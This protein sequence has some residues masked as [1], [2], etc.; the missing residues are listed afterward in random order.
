MAT[1]CT[2]T[3]KILETETANVIVEIPGDGEVITTFAMRADCEQMVTCS[4]SFRIQQWELPSGKLLRAWLVRAHY[5][6][7][8]VHDYDVVMSGQGHHNTP[9]LDITYDVTG[10]LIASGA[11]DHLVRVWDANTGAATHNFK[12]PTAPLPSPI[13]T[14]H[15]TPPGPRGHRRCGCFPPGRP[16]TAALFCW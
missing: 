13:L 2:E 12:V 8:T 16:T 5:Y 3:V 4:H 9:I 1:T 11:A 7:T 15:P 6:A 10:E 14:A